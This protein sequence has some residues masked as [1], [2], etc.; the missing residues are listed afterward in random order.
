MIL[1]SRTF[2]EN[3]DKITTQPTNVGYFASQGLYFPKKK[4][5]LNIFEFFQ[6]RDWKWRCIIK[7]KR[8]IEIQRK[9]N[10]NTVLF[11]RF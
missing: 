7:I 4:F 11:R 1:S 5:N 6:R 2:G 3:F 9:F 8:I 10:K